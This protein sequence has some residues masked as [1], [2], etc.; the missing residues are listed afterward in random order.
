MTLSKV[1]ENHLKTGKKKPKPNDFTAVDNFTCHPVKGGGP[2]V[3]IYQKAGSG[4]EPGAPGK[5]W[6]FTL[7]NQVKRCSSVSFIGVAW[8]LA[9]N[10]R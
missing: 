6:A 2:T 3:F 8:D 4:A 5:F 1:T 9:S 7:Q 10:L